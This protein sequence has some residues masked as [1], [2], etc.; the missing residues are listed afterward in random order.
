MGGRACD[1][2]YPLG[3]QPRCLPRA[4][5]CSPLSHG[6]AAARL[7]RS[8]T[9]KWDTLPA[10]SI[11]ATRS[12]N[13][14]RSSALAGASM[15]RRDRPPAATFRLGFGRHQQRDA[16]SRSFRVGKRWRRSFSAFGQGCLERRILSFMHRSGG[17]PQRAAWFGAG[18]ATVAWVRYGA[19]SYGHAALFRRRNN[20][21]A[22]S[23]FHVGGSRRPAKVQPK[24]Q[25]AIHAPWLTG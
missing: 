11:C 3:T 23:R 18:K 21:P 6:V 20:M 19:T 10:H 1:Q 24:T 15:N 25:A 22:P 17:S 8:T 9:P 12:L 16:E 7:A 4:V 13:A 2:Q 14:A 5:G